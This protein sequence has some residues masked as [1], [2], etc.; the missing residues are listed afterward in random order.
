MK[1]TDKEVTRIY[2]YRRKLR[3]LETAVRKRLELSDKNLNYGA[4]PHI[5]Y[6]TQSIDEANTEL[7]EA[8]RELRK[9]S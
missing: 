4:V 2:N 3:K 1:L 8:Y 9:K 7:D 6:W 5:D